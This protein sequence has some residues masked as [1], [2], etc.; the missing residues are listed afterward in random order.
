MREY[1]VEEL[2]Q[3]HWMF[4]LRTQKLINLKIQIHTHFRF[5]VVSLL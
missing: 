3:Y 1:G 5:F 2:R 4:S